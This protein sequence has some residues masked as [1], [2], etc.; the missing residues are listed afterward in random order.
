V[1]TVQRRRRVAA[2][3]AVAAGLL[4]TTVA[5][6]SPAALAAEGDVL[7]PSQWPASSQVAPTIDSWAH[8]LRIA[9]PDRTQTALALALTLR[10]QGDYPFDTPDP[11]SNGAATLAAANDWWGPGVC[12]RAVIVVA[13]DLPAD[14]LAASA[15]SDPTDGS[16]E[17][18]LERT[19]S[20]DPL[21][22]PIGGFE[23]V[24]TQA[25]PI[26][27][28]RSARQGA[29]GL[30]AGARLAAQDL[31]S[32]G[33][34]LARQA[35]VVGGPAA[36][37]AQVDQELV[38]L[39][40]DEVFR[41]A[42]DTRYD[43]AALVAAA[44]GTGAAA[45][46][47]AT[48]TDPTTD[49]GSARMAFRGNATI[50]LRESATVCQVLGR[51]V[52]LAD[53]IAGA[54]ALA[55]GWWT[56]F[57]QVPVLLHDGTNALPPET[58]LALSTLGVDHVVVLG[59]SSRIPESV[60]A[61]AEDLTGGTA[62]RIGG[63]DRYETSVLMASRF[64]G[65]WPTG[66]ADEFDSS[67]VCLAASSGDG[68]TGAGWPDALAAGPWCG[69]LSGAAVNP[70]APLRALPPLTGGAPTS[71]AGAPARPAH[72]A[73]PVLLVR[74]GAGALPPSVEQFLT[75]A[76]EPA[77]S[78]CTS[79][80][81]TPGCT[82]PGFVVAVGGPT[83]L[84]D[85]VVERASQLVAG[86]AAPAGTT[87]PPAVGG[88]FVTALDLAPVFGNA[89][90]SPDHVCVPRG[91][92]TDTRWLSVL[93]SPDA[94]R[95]LA[96]S[97]VMLL[98]R[99]AADAD[100]VVRSR[101]TLAPSC[102]SL[103]VGTRTA[104]RLRPSGIAGRIGPETSFTVG[105][106][107]EFSLTGPI[108]WSGPTSS[109]GTPSADD[110]SGGGITTQTYVGPTPGVGA[111]SREQV[112]AVTSAAITFTLTRGTDLPASTGIDRFTASFSLTTDAG[113]VSGSA[114]GEAIRGGDGTWRLRGQST[115]AGGS[116][117]VASG[118]G[119]FTLD[120]ATGD[121]ATMA[122]DAISWRVDG[123]VAG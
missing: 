26:L 50:E 33:C 29:T 83:V 100:T 14:S 74:A 106:P 102:V 39:G 24:D 22:D 54:D 52:V 91:D 113:T 41:V 107:V 95:V 87:V 48:C 110:S 84:P 108:E 10:G 40:Y 63:T 97:D 13:G 69:A 57:W 27:V 37:P 7:P 1:T 25:A 46:P 49:D 118:S 93:G 23:R 90:A 34:L 4:L 42:G 80:Q 67:M 43:T 71:T 121:P 17:P 53:G 109:S 70:G 122:D 28:T 30:S 85:A 94:P 65:W 11:S 112:A 60:L 32:G 36:V 8:A 62:V 44:L 88:A 66:R 59:G 117:N 18:Y 79:V 119:G 105:A 72:D 81:A 75:A 35:I 45:A 51:T 77:D 116:W 5:G 12:P 6:S 21:F 99:Y 31:R 9:G 55:A 56:S 101:G 58:A 19:A 76:F 78:F 82:Y 86:S 38:S 73:V 64:G 15:L 20:A 16:S 104:L 2:R 98:G 61:E 114:S 111:V 47:D 123:L 115:F 89:P 96:S 120:L 103:D 92:A 3:L 68:Q